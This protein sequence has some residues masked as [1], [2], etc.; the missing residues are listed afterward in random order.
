MSHEI[1][2]ELMVSLKLKNSENIGEPRK[3]AEPTEFPPI[4]PN[5]SH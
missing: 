1:F 4:H 2:N 3:L 5:C